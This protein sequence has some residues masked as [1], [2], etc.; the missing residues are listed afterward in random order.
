MP[1]SLTDA[2]RAADGTTVGVEAEKRIQAPDLL[3]ELPVG[4]RL[5]EQ[6]KGIDLHPLLGPIQPELKVSMFELTTV[7]LLV[8][9]IPESLAAM[10]NIGRRLATFAGGH[11]GDIAVRMGETVESS[12][13]ERYQVFHDRFGGMAREASNTG[14]HVHVN[15]HDPDLRVEVRNRLEAFIPFLEAISASSP[16]ENG[17]FRGVASQ[18][19]VRSGAMP[20]FTEFPQLSSFDAYRSH[21]L[22]LARKMGFCADAVKMGLAFDDASVLNKVHPVVRASFDKPTVEVRAFGAALTPDEELL[23]V[24]LVVGLVNRI[25]TDIETGKPAFEVQPVSEKARRLWSTR[26]GMDDRLVDPF[27]GDL[28]PAWDVSEGVFAHARSGLDRAGIDKGVFDDLVD[29]IEKRGTGANAIVAEA[30]AILESTTD[31][32]APT[33]EQWRKGRQMTDDQRRPLVG[34]TLATNEFGGLLVPNA[35]E[36]AERASELVDHARSLDP[37]PASRNGQ[38]RARQSLALLP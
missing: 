35:A 11:A 14:L 16:V 13:G 23:Y 22:E 7:I 10:R 25:L 34:W 21:T 36:V 17:Y 29:A 6:F 30:E 8:S 5:Y 15:I 32:S 31:Q 12:P 37:T 24:Y 38:A 20:S 1:V 28:L 19:S 9:E 3:R 2:A 33:L 26:W 27:C 4:A 18:R